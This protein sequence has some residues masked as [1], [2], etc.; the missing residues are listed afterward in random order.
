MMVRMWSKGNIPS[1]LVGV[2]TCKV[3]ME[4][5]M[6]VPWKVGN[7]STLR[8]SYTTLRNMPKGC[9]IL[10]QYCRMLAHVIVALFILSRNWKQP[11]CPSAEE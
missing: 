10:Q 8:P 5:N 4:I 9:S 2:Q 11:K 6:V 1:L 3:T 7:L